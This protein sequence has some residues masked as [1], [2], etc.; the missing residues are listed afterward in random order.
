MGPDT[1]RSDRSDNSD[2][3]DTSPLILDIRQN[4][5]GWED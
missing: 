5:E 1:D 4:W 2:L 3:L